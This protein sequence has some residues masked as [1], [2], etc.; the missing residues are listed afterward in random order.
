MARTIRNRSADNR[1][2][3]FPER[4]LESDS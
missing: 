4:N 3:S 2:L 1:G